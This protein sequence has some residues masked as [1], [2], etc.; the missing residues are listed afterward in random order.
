[1]NTTKTL[2]TLSL[3]LALI[4][5]AF[6]LAPSKAEA[7]GKFISYDALKKNRVGKSGGPGQQANKWS[8]GCSASSRCQR[9]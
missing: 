5:G 7:A 1:M 2:S 6:V 9:N 4:G 3:A 8:R